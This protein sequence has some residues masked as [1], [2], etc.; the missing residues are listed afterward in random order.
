MLLALAAAGL[1]IGAT[2]ALAAPAKHLAAHD[3]GTLKLTYQGAPG[4]MDPHINYTLQGW[5]LEQATM[6]GLVNFKKAQG[7]A[8]YTVVPDLAVAIPKP[9]NGGKTWVFKLRSGIKFSNGKVLKASDVLASFQ[10]IFKVHGPT[11]ASFYGSIVGA[12]ACLKAAATCT[13]KGGVI[14]NDAKGIVTFNLT[15]PDGEWLQQL[16]VPLASILPA[17][18]PAK[19]QGVK[20]VPAPGRTRSSPTTRTARSC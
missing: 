19:D 11:A 20:S 13:L 6:D 14:A 10:R 8:A 15:K 5:Q 7:T 18:T 17:A 9:T 4:S 3:G 16:A 2:C 1:S 12:A